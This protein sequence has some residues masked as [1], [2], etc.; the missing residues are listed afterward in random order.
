M[1]SGKSEIQHSRRSW[2]NVVRLTALVLLTV[3]LSAP[4]SAD[5][6]IFS[7]FRLAGRVGSIAGKVA[8]GAGAAGR[9]GRAAFAAGKLAKGAGL[10]A[11]G[12]RALGGAGS[13]SAAVAAER[14]ALFFASVPDDAV[15][16]IAYIA[17]EGEMLHVVRRGA[18]EVVSLDAA[19]SGAYLES[20]AV[21]SDLAWDP[22]VMLRG[23]S[24]LLP[25]AG[26]VD[27][28]GQVRGW[29]LTRDAWGKHAALR[30]EDEMLR[31]VAGYAAE[32]VDA[33]LTVF[34][35]VQTGLDLATNPVDSGP[36]PRPLVA[37]HLGPPCADAAP[38]RL[39]A[40]ADVASLV[41]LRD[42]PVR[43]L[44]VVQEDAAWNETISALADQVSDDV[45]LVA[46]A[47]ACDA[48]T[49]QPIVHAA[50]ADVSYGVRLP[51][52]VWTPLN[53]VQMRQ[54]DPLVV[55]GSAG[56][57]APAGV[58]RLGFVVP[59]VGS[60]VSEGELSFA[61]GLAEVFVPESEEP[62]LWFMLACGGFA[63]V[64][65]GWQWRKFR[66]KGAAA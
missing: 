60:A 29:T 61:D 18:S 40:V 8:K 30:A 32:G 50:M 11:L 5:A 52:T 57:G 28:L 15:R 33:G 66:T 6:S 16:G 58:L 44:V 13:V 25:G 43:W 47:D 24:D 38:L 17:R 7:L 45:V 63:V 64:Y 1:G 2:S 12:L 62:P 35:L 55:D 46:V 21:H 36:D 4:S 54:D 19:R 39:E 41:A 51:L 53:D 27:S 3:L 20:L 9:A 59:T 34:D 48:A 10:A 31:E 56:E 65:V 42:D 37:V 26:V 23:G 14:A 49:V 22:S